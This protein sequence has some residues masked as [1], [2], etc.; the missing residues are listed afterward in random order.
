MKEESKSYKERLEAIKRAD[1]DTDA[2]IK[3]VCTFFERGG[4]T[5]CI[6]CRKLPVEVEECR[7]YLLER[8]PLRPMDYWTEEFDLF[9]VN[10][11][12]KVSLGEVSGIGINC[13]SCY[14]SEKCPLYKANT[15]CG[16]DWKTQKPET[17]EGYYDFL[18]EIQRERIQ[19]AA[20]F[21]K[22]DGGVPDVGLSG[23]IDRLAG[24]VDGKVNI[25]RE[26]FSLNVEASGP[27]VGGGGILAKLFGAKQPELPEATPKTIE[28]EIIEPEEVKIP[29][30]AKRDVRSK[31]TQAERP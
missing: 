9:V 19:R 7:D 13:D 23:E 30:K 20:V 26:R 21:E 11:R 5:D 15:E 14:M 10:K 24:L 12:E 25:N 3:C 2:L 8:L 22:V 1:G 16:I 17:V 18:I 4:H 31:T 28:A 6:G 27:S 29:R